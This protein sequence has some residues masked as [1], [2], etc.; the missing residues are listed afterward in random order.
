MTLG[1]GT[2]N[3][4]FFEYFFAFFVNADLIYVDVLLNIFTGLRETNFNHFII[5]IFC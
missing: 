5:T 1:Q 2:C 3:V 4:F